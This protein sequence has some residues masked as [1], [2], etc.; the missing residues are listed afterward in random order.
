MWA[1]TAW[2]VEK[3]QV[4]GTNRCVYAERERKTIGKTET[5]LRYALDMLEVC[6]KLTWNLPEISLRY[7]SKMYEICLIC[8]FQKYK[9][10]INLKFS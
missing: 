8:F 9:P 4:R 1:Q 6:Q 10:D 5:C 2:K 3:E 7:V